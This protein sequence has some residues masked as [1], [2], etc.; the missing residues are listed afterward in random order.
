LPL[1]NARKTPRREGIKTALSSGGMQ[2]AAS[3]T[4][5]FVAIGAKSG[6]SAEILP[7]HI[8]TKSL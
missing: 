6:A 3:V 1:K 2:N 8:G 4:E 5:D 7:L